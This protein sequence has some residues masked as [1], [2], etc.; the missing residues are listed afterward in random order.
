LKTLFSGAEETRENADVDC[1]H[2][3]VRLV[4]KRIRRRQ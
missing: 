1:R 3:A 4:A 2:A